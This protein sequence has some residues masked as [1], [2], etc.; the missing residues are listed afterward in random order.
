MPVAPGRNLTLLV[1]VAARNQLLKSRGYDA[2]R[3]FAE[4]VDQMIDGVSGAARG[5]AART[6]GV[7]GGARGPSGTEWES[8][9]VIPPEMKIARRSR[10]ARRRNG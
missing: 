5:A 1:E 4:R 7:Q 10:P 9:R 6:R 8:A 3:R 2:A